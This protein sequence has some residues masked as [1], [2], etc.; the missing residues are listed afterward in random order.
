VERGRQNCSPLDGS[1][2]DCRTCDGTGW[3][4]A[5]YGY[6]SCWTAAGLVAYMDEHGVV[7]PSDQVVIFEGRQVGN[8]F[9]GEPLAVP[10]GD[11]QWTTWAALLEVARHDG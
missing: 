5:M 6:S 2:A 11:V 10:T 9:D 7:N 8:G 4:D 3:E 1:Q